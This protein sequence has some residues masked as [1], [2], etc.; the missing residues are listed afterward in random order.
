RWTQSST[1]GLVYGE[2]LITVC[3]TSV[4]LTTNSDI[5]MDEVTRLGL[6][7]GFTP[8]E[9][10]E[11]KRSNGTLTIA[12][13]RSVRILTRMLLNGLVDAIDLNI[14]T[15]KNEL[16]SLGLPEDLVAVAKNI[17]ANGVKYRISTQ[18][19]PGVL[20]KLNLY[21]IENRDSINARAREY[22]IAAGTNCD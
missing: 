19:Q 17:P 8:A 13:E 21:V 15:I 4:V 9:K 11:E 6:L 5:P 14:A 16:V 12:N 18:S 2:P 20:A 10:W 3:D 22:G 7:Y 1:A